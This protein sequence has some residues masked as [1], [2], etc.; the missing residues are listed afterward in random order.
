MARMEDVL[1]VYAR[2]P[3]PARPLVCFDEG[4]KELHGEVR[5]PLP[6]IPGHPARH[7]AEYERH[8]T[9]NLF[10]WCAPCWGSG[11]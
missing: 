4:S 11:G 10:L 1:D 9:A 2:P 8:G 3:D 7:D 6:A 5:T